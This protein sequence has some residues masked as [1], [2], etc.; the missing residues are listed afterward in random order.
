ML[1]SLETKNDKRN[2]KWKNS[3][4]CKLVSYSKAAIG[5]RDISLNFIVMSRIKSNVMQINFIATCS[6][7]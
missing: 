3:S 5:E 2:Y 4:Q 6:N 1:L 7:K